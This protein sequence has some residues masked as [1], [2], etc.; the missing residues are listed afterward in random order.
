MSE[1]R[2]FSAAL[3]AVA[4]IYNN[5]KKSLAKQDALEAQASL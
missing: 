1:K 4:L 5:K 2:E 3:M